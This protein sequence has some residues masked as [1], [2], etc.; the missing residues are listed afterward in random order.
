MKNVT[1]NN[2]PPRFPRWLLEKIVAGYNQNAMDDLQEEFDFIFEESN[3]KTARMWYRFQVFKSIPYCVNHM[4]YWSFAMY[5]NYLKIALRNL[6][7]QK[8]YSVITL[9]GLVLGAGNIYPFCITV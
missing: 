9:S 1:M 4:I 7:K 6:N 3:L 8:V 2:N 5:K